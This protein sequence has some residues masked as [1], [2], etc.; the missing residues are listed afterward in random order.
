MSDADGRDDVEV[1]RLRKAL[2]VPDV[3]WSAGELE[4]HWRRVDRRLD[5]FARREIRVRDPARAWTNFA[6]KLSLCD[7]NMRPIQEKAAR[8]FLRAAPE[9]RWTAPHCRADAASLGKRRRYRVGFLSAHPFNH[10]HAKAA[11]GLISALSRD[12]F[13]VVLLRL[14]QPTDKFV[15]AIRALAR[16]GHLEA[17]ER[18]PEMT[19]ERTVEVPMPLED[20]RGTVASL[21]LDALIYVDV[22]TTALTYLLALARLAPVQCAM[23]GLPF[24]T[25]APAVDYF[26]SCR[27]AEPPDAESHYTERLVLLDN[28][29]TYY[30][31]PLR[32][33]NAKSRSELGLDPSANL[34]LCP[35]QPPKLHPDFRALLLRI[36]RADP[37]GQLALIRSEDAAAQAITARFE[38]E[39]G[40]ARGR[41]RILPWLA[42]DDYVDLLEVADVVLD[43]MP[44]GG[45]VTSHDTFSVG[46]PIVTLP[47]RFLRGRI[48]AACYRQ[49]GMDG[50]IASGADDYVSLALR[51]GTDPGARNDLRSSIKR[52]NGALYENQGAVRELEAFLGE[53]IQRSRQRLRAG[54]PAGR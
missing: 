28:L 36:V 35:Q 21:R 9:C 14:P 33:A 26:L 15:R 44:W 43:P 19:S 17:L 37:A 16:P 12:L 5:E 51:L 47:G 31:R 52:R 22:G 13:D 10:S 25:G 18:M 41:L 46:T 45:N 38:H 48:T 20:A 42:H 50:G 27:E 39:A 30:R 7:A 53:A 6:T 3:S 23:W 34:Y 49:M 24:T 32:R 54:K 11:A 40:D 29:P 1:G 4:G 8:V 2:A